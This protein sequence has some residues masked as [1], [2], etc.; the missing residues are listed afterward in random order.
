MAVTVDR[1]IAQVLS[2]IAGN[3]Q[4]IVR[5]EMRLVK[6]ELRQD[7]A[8]LRRGAML[9]AAGAVAGILGL[10]FLCLAAAY[11]LASAM[12]MW[13]AALIVA[14]IISTVAA[15]C[16]LTARRRMRGFGLP[17]TTATVQ[18]NVQWMKTHVE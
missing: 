1:P 17:R 8:Q 6:A 15:M 9:A 3:V 2:D 10:A 11:A 5:A 18:E 14:I 13:A 12:P 16:F 7:V 4:S